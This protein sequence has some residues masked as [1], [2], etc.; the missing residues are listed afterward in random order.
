MLRGGGGG[1]ARGSGGSDAI[2]TNSGGTHGYEKCGNSSQRAVPAR[3]GEIRLYKM[4]P[5]KTRLQGPLRANLTCKLTLY[6][7]CT[8]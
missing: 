2:E 3:V 6:T 1:E 7:Y 4:K 5:F 8:L